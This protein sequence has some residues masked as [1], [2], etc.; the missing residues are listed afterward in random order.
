MRRHLILIAALGLCACGVQPA[1]PP[2]A[3]GGYDAVRADARAPCSLVTSAEAA[4]ISGAPFRAH[5]ARDR[6]LGPQTTCSWQVGDP[7]APGLVQLTVGH[8]DAGVTA[9]E[10][11]ALRCGAQARD[12]CTMPSGLV[13]RLA[14]DWTVEASV[15]NP[16]GSVDAAK[17]ERL[18][19]LAAPRVA[20]LRAPKT[21]AS[22][23]APN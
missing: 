9:K 17:S 7:G 8:G 21:Q 22:A 23:R 1:P 10:L 20:E 3:P 14:G 13:V 16:D 12:A 19:A 5:L 6:I 18:A 4:E 11:F 2:G 15:Q